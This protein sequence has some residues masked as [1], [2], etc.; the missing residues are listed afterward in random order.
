MP[1]KPCRNRAATLEICCSTRRRGPSHLA[2]S[3]AK[4]DAHLK[5]LS[6]A[7]RNW[8]EAQ[9]W[10]PKAR[11][12]PASAGRER[13][14]R[15]G[16]CLGSAAR[17]GR[18]S[19]RCCP[20]RCRRRSRRA[21]IASPRRFP[22]RACD[23][24]LARRVL[25][26]QPLQIGERREAEAS[27]AARRRRPSTRPGACRGAL[28]RPRSHQHAG[29]RSR[30]GRAR[31]RRAR[32]RL[33]ARRHRQGDGRLEPALRQFPHDPCRGPGQRP[34]AAAD[35]SPLGLRARAEGDHRRQ[36]HLLRH[37]RSRHQAVEAPWR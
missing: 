28:F 21:I 32:A 3:P 17:I 29:Q 10:A 27:R 6:E 37:R 9:G 25:S 34:R 36:G 12:G 14:H 8:V 26:L 13:R 19:R 35:R 20:A 31:D 16:V 4:D 23:A 5:E 15:R 2:S 11:R 24:R 1:T 30:A 22:T 7:Q 33:R 18:R